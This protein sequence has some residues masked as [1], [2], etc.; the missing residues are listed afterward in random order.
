MSESSLESPSS[1]L[2]TWVGQMNAE[3]GWSGVVDDDGFCVLAGK[4]DHAVVVQAEDRVGTIRFST[5]VGGP[6]GTDDAALLG[7][8]LAANFRGGPFGIGALSLHPEERTV[9]L[10]LVWSD[11]D[12][13]GID[14]FAVLAERFSKLAAVTRRKIADGSLAELWQRPSAADGAAADGFIRA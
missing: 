4:D 7:L 12:R 1:L 6:V 8:L 10:E 14:R 11:V 2:R 5:E 13:G 3:L 9:H